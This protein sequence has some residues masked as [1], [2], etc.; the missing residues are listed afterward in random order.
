MRHNIYKGFCHAAQALVVCC[1]VSPVFSQQSDSR[2]REQGK[3]DQGQSYNSERSSSS[4][5]RMQNKQDQDK[6]KQSESASS[7]SQQLKI[8]P[9]GWV[10][11]GVDYNN[12]GRYDAYETIFV[13]DLQMAQ[14]RSRDRREQSQQQG[15]R[16]QGQREQGQSQSARQSAG[17]S[18]QQSATAKIAGELQDMRKIRMRDS[19][20][21]FVIARVR[22]DEGRTAKV[23]LGKQQQLSGFDLSDGDRIEVEGRRGRINDQPVLVA[24]KVKAGGK[25]MQ[26]EIDRMNQPVR[27]FKG[28]IVRTQTT[29]FQGH[30]KPFVVAEM[31]CQDGSSKLVN[32]GP[33]DKFAD[34][35]VKQAEE[36]CVLAAMGRIDGKKALIAEEVSVDGETIKIK[37]DQRRDQRWSSNSASTSRNS[38]TR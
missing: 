22:T 6:Q 33:K 24:S 8:Q 16:E 34:V 36:V 5:S 19:E 29:R 27:Q 23:L 10:K 1:L 35:D 12:D 28:E 31:R 21:Q 30:D 26:V 18:K 38:S 14:K 7:S 2:Q 4:D 3:R 11:L 20:Q 32:L 15:Q 13:Y 17:G 25:A 9:Q 37:P